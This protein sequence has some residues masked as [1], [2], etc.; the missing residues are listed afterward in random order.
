MKCT[1]GGGA[2][3][4]LNIADLGA[5]AINPQPL[6]TARRHASPPC[7]L[8][9]TVSGV[10]LSSSRLLFL[11]VRSSR[12]DPALVRWDSEWRVR[13]SSRPLS[14]SCFLPLAA[15][16]TIPCW[17]SEWRVSARLVT[18]FKPLRPPCLL[19][20][21]L[22]SLASPNPARLAWC[23]PA[24]TPRK[25]RVHV[26]A[27]PPLASARL[28]ERPQIPPALFRGHGHTQDLSHLLLGL[29]RA[30]DSS[31]IAIGP[32]IWPTGTLVHAL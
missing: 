17:D 27:S 13:S 15:L 8:S 28:L 14:S 29:N 23:R 21:L 30:D 9:P 20:S 6:G 4:I 3:G 2:C 31:I 32:C 25:V 16:V 12:H 22:V 7:A 26:V 10:H 19:S 1:G 18:S 11:W 5:C 24:S